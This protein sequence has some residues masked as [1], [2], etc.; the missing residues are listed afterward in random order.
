MTFQKIS[1]RL[2][3]LAVCLIAIVPFASRVH[4]VPLP[5]WFG[6]INVI[7]L[8]LAAGALLLPT[9]RLFD[10]M[11]RAGWWCLLLAAIWGLQPQFV[12]LMFPG[13][14]YATALGW[15][16]LALLA[17]MTASLRSAF[18]EREFAV[19]LARAII[20]GGL[21]Q[22]LIGAAQLTGLA[23]VLGL[24]YDG[25]HP[26]TNIFGH[27]GQRNQYAHY[28]MWS[29]IS[30]VYLFAVGRLGRGWLTALTLWMALML[31]WAGSR[32]TLLYLLAMAALAA[33]WWWRNRNETSRRLLAA[34]SAVCA[35]VL[36][37]QFALP[38]VNHLVSLLTHADVE[39]ASGVA[40]LAANG[41]DMGARRFTEMHKAWMTFQAHPLWGVGWSQ[42]AAESVRLQQLPQ[43]AAAG[44]NSG[45]FTNA[46]NLVLQLLAEMGGVATVLVL[47]GFV[48][49]LLPFFRRRAEPEG[50]LALGCLAVTLT[51]SMLEYPLWYYYFLAM[52]VLFA[53]MAP[54]DEKTAAWPLRLPL[55]A[56]LAWVG[57]LS[58]STTPMFWE[59]VNL[60]TPTGNAQ[61]D[62]KRT[63]R[64]IAIV[65]TKPLFAYHALY[66]LDDYLPIN[67]DNLRQKLALEDK[68]TAFRPYPDVMLKRAQMEILA[69]QQAKAEQTLR[70]TLA[71]FPTYAGQFLETL[72]DQ[73]PAW[74]PLRR[75]SR[76]A[77]DRLPAKFRTLQE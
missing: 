43:F 22:S 18:G 3:L 56:A 19:W 52:L 29:V 58:I 14:S 6:E 74:E 21:V 72:G 57:W 31:A 30:G 59:L 61:K 11:P 15:L 48:W 63:E 39:N 17:S 42:Y 69:G 47:G 64:L 27:I 32:T 67:R 49:V 34:M 1:E 76:E 75:I 7:W 38:L 71:S 33:L 73:D 44:Y 40:R 24:F 46:H 65:D 50:V 70:T 16:A 9:G 12:S 10:A 68:L 45:L 66:T 4:F 41:D 5:Q 54:R 53:A 13:M 35:V 60:Y 77:Y 26:T 8:L 20:V 28:L 51:H 2:A 62:A 55:L 23:P 25:S 36:A 37:A